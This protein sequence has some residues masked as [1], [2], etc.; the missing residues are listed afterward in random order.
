[1]KSVWSTL[2]DNVKDRR[3]GVLF[4]ATLAGSV[5]LL[6]A[7]GIAADMGVDIAA[8]LLWAG[9][10]AVGWALVWAAMTIHRARK[11]Q[12]ERWTRQELSCDEWRVARSK[13][14][15]DGNRKGA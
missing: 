12:R 15:K 1:M 10:F 4:V 6:I 3:Y 7:V 5:A 2:Y 13:L 9:G 14:K 11:H 8:V